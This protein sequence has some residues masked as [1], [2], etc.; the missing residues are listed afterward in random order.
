MFAL[1]AWLGGI[2][3]LTSN[4]LGSCFTLFNTCAAGV[5]IAEAL[6]RPMGEDDRVIFFRKR[7]VY[8]M[9]KNSG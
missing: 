6:K 9:I 3:I 1:I 4:S 7:I 2:L 5:R 8:N